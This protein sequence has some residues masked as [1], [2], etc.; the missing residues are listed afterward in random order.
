[1]RDC[2]TKETCKE[3]I[4]L[5]KKEMKKTT[6]RKMALMKDLMEL[7]FPYRRNEI[8]EELSPIDSV[9]HEYLALG[10]TSEVSM[11]NEYK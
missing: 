6:N 3:H 10:L 8:L 11:L 1:M 9:M 4:S 7:T 2:E 5:L